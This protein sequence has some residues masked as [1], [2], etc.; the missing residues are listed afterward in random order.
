VQP[1][2][3]KVQE[4]SAK[5]MPVGLGAKKAKAEK[6]HTETDSRNDPPWGHSTLEKNR[7]RGQSALNF[8]I[9]KPGKT[10]KLAMS[11]PRLE[12]SP[13]AVKKEKGKRKPVKP[14]FDRRGGPSKK[15]T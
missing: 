15:T 3:R 5:K 2:R 13:W 1:R 12:E 4:K 11:A 6:K 9:K 7:R 14:L 10:R 8:A